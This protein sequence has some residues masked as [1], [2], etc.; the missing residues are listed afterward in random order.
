MSVTTKIITL[1]NDHKDDV[2]LAIKEADSSGK[3]NSLFQKD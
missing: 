3:A 1:N 2:T